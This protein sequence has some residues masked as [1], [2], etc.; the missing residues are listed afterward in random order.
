MAPQKETPAEHGQ[1]LKY[2]YVLIKLYTF[3][4]SKGSLYYI[5]RRLFQVANQEEVRVIQESRKERFYFKSAVTAGFGT[6]AF[7]AVKL[8]MYN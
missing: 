3:S 4:L 1:L 6:L 5:L 8:G 7:V 2:T